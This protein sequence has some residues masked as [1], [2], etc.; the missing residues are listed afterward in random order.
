MVIKGGFNRWV[1]AFSSQINRQRFA[2]YSQTHRMCGTVKQH[3][4]LIRISFATSPQQLYILFAHSLNT[5]PLL[6]NSL[7][8]TS[9][10]SVEV[11][12]AR[13]RLAR[14][15]H[16]DDAGKARDSNYYST[17]I[18][19]NSIVELTYN[20]VQYIIVYHLVIIL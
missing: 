6:L 16:Q 17:G 2:Y 19:H 11:G 10:S 18:V 1:F 9:Y 4:L 13:R 3:R 7:L 12:A 20:I 5:P 15:A 8:S 14:P